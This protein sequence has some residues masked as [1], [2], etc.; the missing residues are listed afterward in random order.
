MWNAMFMHAGSFAE[1]SAEVAIQGCKAGKFPNS[2]ES[3]HAAL[4]ETLLA[5]GNIHVTGV[6]QD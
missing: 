6:C 4:H 2:L 3:K 5:S 1:D